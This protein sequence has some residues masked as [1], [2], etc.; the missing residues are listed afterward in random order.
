MKDKLFPISVIS[1]RLI[2]NKLYNN[3]HSDLVDESV[4]TR[5]DHQI[6]LSF[7]RF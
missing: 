4:L 7:Y 2:N 3:N 6:G 1:A 5:R